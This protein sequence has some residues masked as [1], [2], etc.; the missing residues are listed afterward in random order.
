MK[1]SNLIKLVSILLIGAM[2]AMFS[3]PVFAADDD[4][5]DLTESLSGNNNS[6]NSNSNANANNNNANS[7][8]NNNNSNTNSNA[9]N[10]NS[11]RAN[12]NAN[13]NNNNANNNNNSVYNN[14]NLPKT[15]IGDSFPVAMLV[16][17]FGISAVYAYK[18]VKDYR[19]I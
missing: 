12:N 8:A 14:N 18:K 19:N 10:N 13:A 4:G 7:N 1:K 3:V 15:G 16:V 11:N 2:V 17:I 9:N 6:G 5:I